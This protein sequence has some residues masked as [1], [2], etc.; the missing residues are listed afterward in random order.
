MHSYSNK[1]IIDLTKVLDQNLEIYRDGSYSDPQLIVEPWSTIKKQG[2]SVCSIMLGTQT[3]THIDAPAHFIEGGSTLDQLQIDK[4]IGNYFWCNMD[5]LTAESRPE[6]LLNLYND[7]QILFL[8]SRQEQIVISDS[9]FQELCSIHSV[10]FLPGCGC[11]ADRLKSLIGTPY[12]FI[13]LLL[14]IT[15]T[16]Q[17]ILIKALLKK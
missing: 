7:E 10:Q 14:N 1:E 9:I 2:F 8:A 13:V 15:S 6:E 3:G 16:W 5:L 4:L 17:K 12:I 11:S